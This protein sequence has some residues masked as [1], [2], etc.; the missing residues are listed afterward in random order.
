VSYTAL[1]TKNPGDLLTSALWNT[2]LQGNADSGFARM[3]ADTT[4]VAAA[5]SISFASI[6]ATFAHLMLVGLARGDTAATSIALQLRFNNDSAANYN[7]E[8]LTATAA[9]AAAATNTGLT[10]GWGNAI[11]A[12][13]A[14]AGHFS[15][16]VI[17]I[18]N[19]A[20]ATPDKSL[21]GLGFLPANPQLQIAGSL[22]A[23]TAAINRIDL[24]AGAGNLLAGTRFTLYGLPQ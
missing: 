2:Y 15:P 10:A 3:L 22:W 17:F 9:V 4:L 14:A 1:P 11:P 8:V 19:Y 6:P 18:P 24:F 13:T 21:F 16:V 23:S 20:S 5:A 7:V 12:A